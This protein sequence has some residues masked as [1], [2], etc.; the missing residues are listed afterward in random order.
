MDKTEDN[1]DKTN[2]EYH[3]NIINELLQKKRSSLSKNLY[4][5]AII[6][7][8]YYDEEF[9]KHLEATNHILQNLDERLTKIENYMKR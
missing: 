2:I 4:N 1:D 8:K 5:K 3:F 6:S 7:G 9:L